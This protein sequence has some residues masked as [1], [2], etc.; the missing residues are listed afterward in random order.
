MSTSNNSV[1]NEFRQVAGMT[2]KDIE[3]KLPTNCK[4]IS[5]PQGYFYYGD[6]ESAMTNDQPT[7]YFTTHND[8]YLYC[9]CQMYGKNINMKIKSCRGYNDLIA[10]RE[11][12]EKK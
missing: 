4:C 2:G 5:C 9:F 7:G 10:E 3:K 8:Q 12:L 11:K 1:L 6:V